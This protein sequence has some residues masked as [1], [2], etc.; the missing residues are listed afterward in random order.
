MLL[1]GARAFV[2]EMK[3]AKILYFG[4][5][6]C[7]LIFFTKMGIIKPIKNVVEGKWRHKG[8]CRPSS[9]FLRLLLYVLIHLSL[10]PQS[11]SPY[12]VFIYI[13]NYKCKLP[14][15]L[16]MII[17]WQLWL[18]TR[19]SSI[20]YRVVTSAISSSTTDNP[21]SPMRFLKR[22]YLRIV[23]NLEMTYLPVYLSSRQFF[24]LYCM[25]I[26][27]I[28]FAAVCVY[29][30]FEPFLQKKIY[31]CIKTKKKVIIKKQEHCL[32]VT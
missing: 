12:Y 15:D 31:V 24:C 26:F 11:T 17:I 18:A 19:A 8:V 28:I 10:G 32:Q 21:I 27:F 20:E 6:Y 7:V 3:V 4:I 25:F 2:L 5:V 23:V 1:P 30:H 13:I 9:C 22:H 14:D 29:N 16:Y